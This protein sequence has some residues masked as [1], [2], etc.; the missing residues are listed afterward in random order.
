[1]SWE[2]T[3]YTILIVFLLI[4]VVFGKQKQEKRDE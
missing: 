3:T 2:L 4:I 1:M